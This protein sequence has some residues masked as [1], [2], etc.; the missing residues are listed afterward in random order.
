MLNIFPIQ[1][2]ALFA[3]FILRVWIGGILLYLGMQHTKSY[4]ELVATTTCPL[5][6]KHQLPIFII[7]ACEFILGTVLLAGAYTQLVVFGI[8]MLS[9]KMILWRRR[10][11]HKS[12]PDRWFYFL[13]IGC[14]LSLFITGA[15]AIAF[16]LPI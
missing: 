4:R 15:G 5:L 10:F 12:I 6:P 9:L 16:D 14:C 1:W 8:L 11:T 7:I 3:Y 2:L 13:L